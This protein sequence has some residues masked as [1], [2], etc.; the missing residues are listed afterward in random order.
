M[1]LEVVFTVL[2]QYILAQNFEFEKKK[3]VVASSEDEATKKAVVVSEA[4]GWCFDFFA[5]D[6]VKLFVMH[7]MYPVRNY[8]VMMIHSWTVFWHRI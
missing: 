1:L 5:V 3:A 8:S 6:N 7:D 4:V 2:R